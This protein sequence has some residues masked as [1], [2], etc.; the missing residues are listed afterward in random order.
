ML[1]P[2]DAPPPPAPARV[3]LLDDH[4]AVRRGVIALLDNTEDLRVVAAGASLQDGVRDLLE[5]RLR[6]DVAVLDVRLACGDG[7]GLDLCRLLRD[8]RPELPVVVLTA[9]VGD[10]VEQR[11]AAAGARAVVLKSIRGTEVLDA[12]RRAVGHPGA[13]P[14]V[15]GCGRS[16]PRPPRPTTPAPSRRRPGGGAP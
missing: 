12:L 11:A 14:P 15:S 6:V 10:G 1:E 16:Q 2:L 5:R 4:E 7:D 13:R 8:R 9:H 3:Y